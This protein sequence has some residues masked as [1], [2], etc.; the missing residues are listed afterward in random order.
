MGIDNR[1]IVKISGQLPYFLHFHRFQIEHNARIAGGFR[2]I[3]R[4]L[5][6]LTPRSLA[7]LSAYAAQVMRCQF[8]HTDSLCTVFHYVTDRL[9]CHLSP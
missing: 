8:C 5:F 9:L 1:Q 6:Q 3:G 4:D 7:Q 2:N